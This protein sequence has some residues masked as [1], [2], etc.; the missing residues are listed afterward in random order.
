[1][2]KDSATAGV[3]SSLSIDIGP[4]RHKVAEVE[5]VSAKTVISG[6]M[7]RKDPRTDFDGNIAVFARCGRMTVIAVAADLLQRMRCYEPILTHLELA[8]LLLP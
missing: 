4:R 3:L 8:S 2:R 1:M 7:F 5:I 6:G